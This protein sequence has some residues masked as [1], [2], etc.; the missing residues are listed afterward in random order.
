MRKRGINRST[1][2][3]VEHASEIHLNIMLTGSGNSATSP[4]QIMHANTGLMATNVTLG[5]RVRRGVWRTPANHAET[6]SFRFRT[7]H[8]RSAASNKYSAAFAYVTEARM[9]CST[10]NKTRNSR[11]FKRMRKVLGSLGQRGEARLKPRMQKFVLLHG[12][13]R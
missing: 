10:T 1:I 13:P 8:T 7:R 4:V 5:G 12:S 3:I 6:K 2:E 11:A 9:A